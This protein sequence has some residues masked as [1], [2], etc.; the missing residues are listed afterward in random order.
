LR[1]RQAARAGICVR[2]NGAHESTGAKS[3]GRRSECVRVEVGN[4]VS[5]AKA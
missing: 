2:Q 4:T 5:R 1:G 3:A